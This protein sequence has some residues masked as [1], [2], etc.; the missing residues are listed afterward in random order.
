[1]H[2]T[3]TLDP[4]AAWLLDGLAGTPTPWI[5]LGD[6]QLPDGALRL[7]VTPGGPSAACPPVLHE[8][9]PGRP[10]VLRGEATARPMPAHGEATARPMAARGEPAGH[11]P[12]LLEPA[13]GRPAVVRAAAA[14]RVLFVRGEAAWGAATLRVTAPDVVPAVAAVLLAARD[15]TGRVPRLSCTWPQRRRLGELAALIDP[16]VFSVPRL[17]A[18][19]RRAEPVAARRPLVSAGLT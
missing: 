4:A 17:R 16:A 18:L 5:V 19:L 9:A 7:I 2:N 1:M 10:T 14:G 15:R 3:V 12:V 6:G 13:R 8:P 11:P